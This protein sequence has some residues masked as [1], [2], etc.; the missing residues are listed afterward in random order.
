MLVVPVHVLDAEV[1]VA[2]L[3]EQHLGEPAVERR[4]AVPVRS[5]A[6]G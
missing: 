4:A 5:M 1:G 2:D 6:S 3:G